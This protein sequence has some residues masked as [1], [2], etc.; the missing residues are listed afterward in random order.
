M[1]DVVIEAGP[2]GPP[3]PGTPASGPVARRILGELWIAREKL[4][5]VGRN[6]NKSSNK[7]T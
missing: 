2:A 4:S 3:A 6:W 1:V 7:Q 5:Q